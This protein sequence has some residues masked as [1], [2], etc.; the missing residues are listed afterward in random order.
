MNTENV[1]ALIGFIN[2]TIGSDW[3]YVSDISHAI[4][5]G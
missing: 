3:N 5:S 1:K 4:M 2:E